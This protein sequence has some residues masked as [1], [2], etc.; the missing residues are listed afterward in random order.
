MLRSKNLKQI[1]EQ[2]LSRDICTCAVFGEDGVVLAHASAPLTSNSGTAAGSNLPGGTH[3]L[4]HM[5]TSYRGGEYDH[6]QQQQQQQNHPPP[7]QHYYGHEAQTGDYG[8]GGGVRQG[9][10]TQGTAGDAGYGCSQ[11]TDTE[12]MSSS[13]N[14][15]LLDGPLEL[16]ER[17]RLDSDLAIAA[18][19]WQSYEG[20]SGLVERKEQE[21]DDDMADADSEMQDEGPGNPLNM[22][23]IDSELGKVVVTRLGIYR[24]FIV[25][26]ASTPLGLLKHKAIALCRFLE[27]CLCLPPSQLTQPPQ[28]LAG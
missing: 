21:L 19:L 6:Q 18:S 20:M 10:G 24:L 23:I 1:L 4:L 12:S 26:K 9:G 14:D 11:L 8:R 3:S 27:E 17:Q 16:Q 13:L 28:G 7:H 22:I 2:A 25:S 5:S 15:A